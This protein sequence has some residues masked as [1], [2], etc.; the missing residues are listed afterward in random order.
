MIWVV[1]DLEGGSA[2]LLSG[3]GSEQNPIRVGELRN[4]NVK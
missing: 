2:E 3:V 1:N 4:Q